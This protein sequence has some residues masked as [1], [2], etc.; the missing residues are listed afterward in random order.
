MEIQ[1]LLLKVYPKLIHS[2][3]AVKLLC[4]CGFCQLRPDSSCA[5]IMR[6]IGLFSKLIQNLINK[7]ILVSLKNWFKEEITNHFINVKISLQYFTYYAVA[8]G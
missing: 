7:K 2:S 3:K 5:F 1:K 6:V 4:Y 8:D